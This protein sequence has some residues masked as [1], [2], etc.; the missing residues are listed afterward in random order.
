MK[1]A[2]CLAIAATVAGCAASF[3]DRWAPVI[4]LLEQQHGKAN[5]LDRKEPVNDSIAH[6]S[7]RYA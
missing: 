1:L 5:R 3:E 7:I 2:I 4:P 6:R